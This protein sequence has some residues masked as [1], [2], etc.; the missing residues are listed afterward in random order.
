MLGK[1]IP[2]P[3]HVEKLPCPACGS[4]AIP[5]LPRNLLLRLFSVLILDVR[6]FTHLPTWVIYVLFVLTLGLSIGHYFL[7]GTIEVW[8]VVSSACLLVILLLDIVWV[9][10]TMEVWRCKSCMRSF[11]RKRSIR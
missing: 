1:R 11:I 2:K 9:Q 7:Y 8:L 6:S 3:V 4:E 5:I 10:K